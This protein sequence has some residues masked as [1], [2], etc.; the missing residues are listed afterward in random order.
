MRVAKL[1]LKKKIISPSDPSTASGRHLGGRAARAKVTLNHDRFD[2]PPGSRGLFQG[3]N[4]D[5]LPPHRPARA[6]ATL[7]CRQPTN[8]PTDSKK[9]KCP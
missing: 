1:E 2:T 3:T 5:R 7:Q 4:G 8:S 9:F 6:P